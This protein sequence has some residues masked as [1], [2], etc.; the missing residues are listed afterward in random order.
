MY[1]FSQGSLLHKLRIFT[2]RVNLKI[3]FYFFS[4]PEIQERIFEEITENIGEDEGINHESISKLEYLE[5]SL[6]ET[7]RM[8][9][10]ATGHLRACTRDCVVKGIKFQKGMS[11]AMW[12]Y[13]S[14][15]YPKFYPDPEVFKPER[16][17]KE[18]SDQV[19]PFTWRPFGS[20]QRVCIGQRYAMVGM[21]LFMAKFIAKFKLLPTEKTKLEY[22]TP[23][24]FLL[25][26]Y[27]ESVAKIE[28]RQ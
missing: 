22:P 26:S 24:G 17:L 16:F 18:N 25:I 20:G 23:N 3:S 28:K 27:K 15:Y 10:P 12:S 8:C 19:I 7:M 14:H 4:N 2:I 13:A 9:P 11:V 1:T 6:M 21:K 5:A